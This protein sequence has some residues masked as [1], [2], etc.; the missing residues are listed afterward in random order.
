MTTIEVQF[1]PKDLPAWA[2]DISEVVE[3]CAE[4]LAF[5]ANVCL[6]TS[7]EFRSLLIK[8]AFRHIA[9]K[10]E[11]SHRRLLDKRF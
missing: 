8:E 3:R 4:S 1:D 7:N 9:E 11:E 6:A 10:E 5:R 2:Q